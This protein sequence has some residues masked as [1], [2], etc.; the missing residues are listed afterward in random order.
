MEIL[1]ATRVAKRYGGVVALREASITLRPGEIHALVGE[2][3]A[4]KSTLVKIVC[5]VTRPDEGKLEVDGVGVSFSSARDAT[6]HGISFVSQELSMFPDL[7]V[8]EN[9]FPHDLPRRFGLVSR[10]QIERRAR[11]LFEEFDLD[12]GFDTVVGTLPLSDQQ[13]LEICRALLQEPKV[14]VLDEPTSAQPS[15]AVARLERTLAGLVGRGLAVLYISHFLEEVMRLSHRVSVMRDGVIALEGVATS[16]V[17]LHSLVVAMLGE[18]AAQPNT[19]RTLRQPV[20]LESADNAGISTD[21][22]QGALTLT[23]VTL[24]GTLRGVSL[25]VR[26]SEVVGLAGLQGAGHLAVLEAVC[27]RARPESGDVVLPD[28][29][30]PRT[31]RHA[32]AHGVA[33]VP[34]DRKRLG[35]MLD[36]AAWE[37]VSSVSWLGLDGG[38]YFER[39]RTLFARAEKHFTRLR[40]RGTV[41]SVVSD[42]SG[43]NQQKVVF[44][45]WLDAEPRVVVLDDP[46]RGVDVGARAEMHTVIR[47]F[48][49]AGKI[50][51]VASTDLAELV[52]VCDRV[53]VFQHG[54]I[55]DELAGSTLDERALSMAMNAG[56][57]ETR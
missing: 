8:G 22:T 32:I 29:T 13:Q 48:A 50:V 7:T 40:I 11:P 21:A 38:G 43:G 24:P 52:E 46:T 55:V 33:F 6:A 23:D 39:R 27:G 12:V 45:K 44:A 53:L 4:G 57:A 56:F 17:S 28:G 2:N 15:E 10:R 54:R 49:D 35:L 5:G 20:P 26:P 19:E 42:L 31:L 25:S 36:K 18:Q 14:L 41:S 9:L 16:D 1:R 34:G 30:R 51:V 37:N 3:G 47:A